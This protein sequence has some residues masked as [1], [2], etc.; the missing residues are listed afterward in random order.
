MK[1]IQYIW[2]VVEPYPSE[3]SWSS[4]VG[5]MTFPTEWKFIKFMF[6]TTNQI[7]MYNYHIWRDEHPSFSYVF[8]RE[9]TKT[10]TQHKRLLI[11]WTNFL[12]KHS[13]M[14]H[15]AKMISRY[16]L[17]NTF[18]CL[19]RQRCWSLGVL[20]VGQKHNLTRRNRP[21]TFHDDLCR[22]FSKFKLN[23]FSMSPRKC[24]GKAS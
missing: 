15:V 18:P 22:A 8:K 4:S 20:S 13:A 9:S 5:M 23:S 6:Q 17:R 3:K 21:L 16:E 19:S 12:L 14:W 24:V 10:T 7:N 2:L 11:L 1:I